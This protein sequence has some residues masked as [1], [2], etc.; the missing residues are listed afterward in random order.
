MLIL[1]AVM[2]VAL[3]IAYAIVS[4]DPEATP[5][6]GPTIQPED[7][8]TLLRV[9][10]GQLIAWGVPTMASIIAFLV[11]MWKFYPSEHEEG[12]VFRENDVL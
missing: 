11:Y 12:R 8:L 1:A 2:M 6:D 7:Y 10:E 4:P 5:Q 3:S 9:T